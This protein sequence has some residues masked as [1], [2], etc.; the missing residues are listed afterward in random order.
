MLWQGKV[1]E[2]KN[3]FKNFKTQA[4]KALP[5]LVCKKVNNFYKN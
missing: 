2:V 3:L 5:N 1:D 4:F